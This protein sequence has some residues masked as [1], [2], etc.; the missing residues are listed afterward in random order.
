MSAASPSIRRGRRTDFT[1][2]MALLAACEVPVP[3]PDR[4]TLHRFRNIVADLGG[5]FYVA[6]DGPRL[7]GLVHLTYHRRLTTAARARIDLLCVHPEYRRHGLGSALLRFARKRAA[8]RGCALLAGDTDPQDRESVRLLESQGLRPSAQTWVV[9][10]PG[11][12][13]APAREGSHG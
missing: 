4:A 6:L 9:A 5:D 11:P 8:K 2:T 10:L 12:S 3:P 1:A 13:D 7:I